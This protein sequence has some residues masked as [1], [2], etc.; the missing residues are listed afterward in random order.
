MEGISG[1]SGIHK[2]GAEINVICITAPQ[3]N[4]APPPIH[5]LLDH[6]YI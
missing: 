5:V 1:N 2:R 6:A 4:V 3:I